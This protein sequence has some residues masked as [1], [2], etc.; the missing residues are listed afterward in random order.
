MLLCVNRL[1]TVLGESKKNGRRKERLSTLGSLPVCVF[2]CVYT[3]THAC[4]THLLLLNHAAEER[5]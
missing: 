4:I 1:S 3:H 2:V 5:Q